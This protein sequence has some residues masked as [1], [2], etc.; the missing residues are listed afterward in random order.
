DY[1][2]KEDPD[3]ADDS[4]YIH[5]GAM[6]WGLVEQIKDKDSVPARIF[7]GLGQLEKIRKSE[8]VFTCQADTWTIDT[9]DASVLCIGRYNEGE[10]ILGIFNFSE[11]DKTAWINE[12]DGMYTDM[13]SGEKRKAAGVDIPAYG[14]LYL[15]RDEIIHNGGEDK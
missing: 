12:T 11:Y 3:K 6:D 13:L 15:K 2:Y 10:K 5:R 8:K 1:T 7:D 14:F 9:F 4:R